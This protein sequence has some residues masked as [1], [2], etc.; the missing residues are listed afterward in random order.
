MTNEKARAITVCLESQSKTEL[1]DNQKKVLKLMQ[2]GYQLRS[3]GYYEGLKHLYIVTLSV[4]TVT[5]RKEPLAQ[6]EIEKRSKQCIVTSL[7]K[8]GFIKPAR[9]SFG[10]SGSVDYEL[11]DKGRQIKIEGVENG[12]S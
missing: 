9:S 10:D 5:L 6:H 7:V 2:E 12:G 1:T 3:R 8:R 11:T 4:Q